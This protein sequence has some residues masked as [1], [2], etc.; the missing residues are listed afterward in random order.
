MKNNIIEMMIV[1]N[2]KGS[3][4]LKETPLHK[5][6]F[7]SLFWND[8]EFDIFEHVA[9]V[10]DVKDGSIVTNEV[11]LKLLGETAEYG[12]MVCLKGLGMED[13]IPDSLIQ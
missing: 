12:M 2:N 5:D 6:D 13:R 1:E 7:V 4:A 10:N 3:G 11:A 9:L 8:I